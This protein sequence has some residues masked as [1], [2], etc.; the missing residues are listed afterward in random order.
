MLCRSQIATLVPP[1]L[2]A[3]AV[4]NVCRA[5]KPLALI[6]IQEVCPW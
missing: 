2:L 4:A 1:L 3:T 5:Q 6:Y